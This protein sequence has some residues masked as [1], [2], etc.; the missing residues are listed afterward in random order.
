V[1]NLPAGENVMRYRVGTKTSWNAGGS[2]TWTSNL[3]A[4]GLKYETVGYETDGFG[5][6]SLTLDNLA[7][8]ELVFAWADDHQGSGGQND[9]D[10]HYRIGWNDEPNFHR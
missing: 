10:I 4:P 2:A 8:P 9:N 1:D 7:K 3:L 5:L 6:G